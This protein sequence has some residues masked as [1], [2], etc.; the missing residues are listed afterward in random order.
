MIEVPSPHSGHL[1]AVDGVH[2]WHGHTK[3]PYSSESDE[4]S[5]LVYSSDERD[6][7]PPELVCSKKISPVCLSQRVGVAVP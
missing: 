1:A 7:E 4:P 2:L 6:S 3:G 5:E